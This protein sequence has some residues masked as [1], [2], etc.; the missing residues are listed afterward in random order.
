MAELVAL[1][2]KPPDAVGAFLGGRRVAGEERRAALGERQMQMQERDASLKNIRNTMEMIGSVALGSMGGKL[3]GEPDPAMYEQGLDFLE[4]NGM[5][6]AKYRGKPELAKV[7]AR[8]SLDVLQAINLGRDEREWQ[9]KLRQFDMTMAQAAMQM[10]ASQRRDERDATKFPAEMDL[11]AAQTEKAK[12]DADIKK[13][14]VGKQERALAGAKRDAEN[15]KFAGDKLR[16]MITN[17]NWWN[18]AVGPFAETIKKRGPGGSA[19]ANAEALIDTI[20]A[21]ISFERLQRMRNES[22][23]GGALGNV[24]NFEVEALRATLASLKQSQSPEQFLE[25]LDRVMAQFNEVINGPD[26]ARGPS[27]TYQEQTALPVEQRRTLVPAQGGQSVRAVPDDEAEID[28]L[29]E[30]YDK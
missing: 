25:N 27:Q 2:V 13:T 1:G 26:S 22:P 11:L 29:I 23:T 20:G 12:A 14:G 4:Q 7:A 30:M 9:L 5:D 18:P 17:Q 28:R 24:S 8:G 10:A 6:V 3:E 19:A 16:E 15:V 21:N